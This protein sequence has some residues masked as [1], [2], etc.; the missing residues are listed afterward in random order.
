MPELLAAAGITG[1]DFL[2]WQTVL[3]A[4]AVLLAVFT[5][6]RMWTSALVT[7]LVF[8]WGCQLAV[9]LWILPAWEQNKPVRAMSYEIQRRAQPEDAVGY[10]RVAF[11]SLCFYLQRPI[12]ELIDERHFIQVI[13]RSPN[14]KF[15][16][17]QEE[18]YTKLQPVLEKAGFYVVRKQNLW[19]WKLQDY[20]GKNQDKNS[21]TILLIAG[22]AEKGDNRR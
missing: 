13:L 18:D 7:V 10:Y 21:N 8:L 17:L 4:V 15:F 12:E 3:A 1:R 19:R 11:P 20:W 22:P 6:R 5:W 9:A 14:R 16:L 2:Q